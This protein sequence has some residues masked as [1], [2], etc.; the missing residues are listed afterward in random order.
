MAEPFTVT[1]EA[2]F[3]EAGVWIIDAR[4]K[5]AEPQGEGSIIFARGRLALVERI[6]EAGAR[7][8]S[9]GAKHVRVFM[10]GHDGTDAAREALR[11]KAVA[12]LRRALDD[13][14]VRAGAAQHPN[15]GS[16]RGRAD[17]EALLAR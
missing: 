10:A 1:V 5:F 16:L 7:G 14:E 8:R 4:L 3:N 9:L 6:A 11:T 17:Y 12:C 2:G 13:R 15:F